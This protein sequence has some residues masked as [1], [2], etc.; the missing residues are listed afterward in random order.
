MDYEAPSV[1]AVTEVG[2]PLIGTI[3]SAPI[4]PQ[5]NDEVDAS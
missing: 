1:T 2:T 3:P 4:N 5:W